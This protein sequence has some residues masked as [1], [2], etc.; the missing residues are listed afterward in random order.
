MKQLTLGKVLPYIIGI[1]AFYIITAV[2]FYPEI[3]EGKS[4]AQDDI[5]RYE[6][7]SKE[8]RDFNAT[9]AEPSMWTNS[10]FGGM[11]VYV[12]H[13]VFPDQPIAAIDRLFKG[14]FFSGKAAHMLFQ[15]MLCMFIALA[16]FGV[17]P[18]VAAIA[19][20]AFGL[21]TYNLIIIEVGHMTKAWAIAYAPLVLAGIYLTFRGKLLQGFT[22]TAL[23]LALEIRAA[24][25][26]IT[27]YLAFVCAIYVAVELVRAITA[28][29]LPAFAKT[30]GVLILAAGLALAANAGR[31]LTTAD[32]GKYSQRGKAELTP[33]PGEQATNP[34]DGLNRDY[35]FSWSQGIAETFTLILPNFY[36]GSNNEKLTPQSQT[37]RFLEQV[38]RA[39]Q[40]NNQDFV[41]F[42]TRSPF[43]YWGDQPFT[44]APVYAGAIICF[45]FVWFLTIATPTQR[46]WLLGGVVLML[47][48]SWGSNL[49]FFNYFMFDYFP[50]FNKFRSVSMA[51][52]LAVMLI[53]IGA[54]MGLQRALSLSEKEHPNWQKKLGIAFALTGGLCALFFLISGAFSFSGPADEQFGSLIDAVKADR[55]AMFRSDALRSLLLIAAAAALLY[56]HVKKKVSVAVAVA[57]IGGLIVF[58]GWSVGRRYLN[59]DSFQLQAKE[60]AHAPTPADEAILKDKDLSYRVLNLN[61]PFNDAATSYYHKS[62]GGYFAAKLRRY[63]DLI[64]RRLET[65]IKYL[66][67]SLQKGKTPDFSRTP[68]LNMLNTRYLILNPNSA[69]GVLRNPAALGNAWFITELKAVSSPDEEM[70]ALATLAPDSVAVIDSS[71]FPNV[72]TGRY[73]RTGASI[74]LTAYAPNRLEYQ[75]ECPDEGFAVFS[76]IYYPDGWHVTINGQKASEFV[77]VNYVLRGLPIPKGKHT[78][79]CTF[80]PEL[81]KR[82]SLITMIASYLL[83]VALATSI[84]LMFFRKS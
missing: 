82:G 38:L 5:L 3:F 68:A 29:Q 15:T 33:L 11:P 84:G 56:F 37:Y 83:V 63:Q 19:A 30:I 69:E 48:F 74:R 35:A 36:G 52:S 77:R 65:E 61:N 14:L 31:L 73:S 4:L 17:S 76:E 60:A 44:N 67:D 72:K 62:V 50:G 78:I 46:Y 2:Y 12:L 49:A 32:Y 64:N 1:V 79:V 34:K 9:H 43:M 39:G 80:E 28:K 27:Y 40:I 66:I 47:M 22:L 6:G 7:A 23:A 45:L 25:L 58:D 53:V 55:Q 21:S 20:A 24:H 71:K 8:V 75:A 18:Y 13:P 26:Q 70:A 16:V 10:M 42:T 81:Y 51:L 59:E 57:T 54:A 41:Q